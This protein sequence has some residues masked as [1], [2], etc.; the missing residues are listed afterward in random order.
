VRKIQAI[1]TPLLYSNSL[2]F[3]AHACTYYLN[4]EVA[5]KQREFVRRLSSPRD[6]AH[7]VKELLLHI[8][9]PDFFS[10]SE[11]RSDGDWLDELFAGLAAHQP[12]YSHITVALLDMTVPAAYSHK[13][14]PR[15]RLLYGMGRLYAK[16]G[17]PG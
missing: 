4:K 9:T 17:I 1:G 15:G 11:K 16:N 5:E 14:Q 2:I 3:F 12:C 8:H 13:R 6:D 10:T 7:R